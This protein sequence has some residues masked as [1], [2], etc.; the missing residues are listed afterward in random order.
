MAHLR[1]LHPR[2]TR[3]I[4]RRSH[5]YHEDVL[6]FDG[7]ITKAKPSNRRERRYIMKLKRKGTP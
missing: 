7:D 4:P 6:K 2:M 5:K 1:A 3:R